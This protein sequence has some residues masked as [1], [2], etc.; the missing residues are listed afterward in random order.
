MNG[1]NEKPIR[2]T[3]SQGNI[4]PQSKYSDY[5]SLVHNLEYICN[6]DNHTKIPPPCPMKK[7]GKNTYQICHYHNIPGHWTSVCFVLRDTVEQLI[8][9]GSLRQFVDQTWEAVTPQQ[10]VQKISN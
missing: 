10:A 6:I 9:E 4:Q 8:R 5:A 1:S 2:G 7:Q 3:D